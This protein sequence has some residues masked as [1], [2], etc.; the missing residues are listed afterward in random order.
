MTQRAAPLVSKVQGMFV[1][2]F[3][4]YMASQHQV[5]VPTWSEE[6]KKNLMAS[7]RPM[8]SSSTP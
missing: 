5:Y 2:D 4:A 6:Q 7:W 3:L 1:S 8:V